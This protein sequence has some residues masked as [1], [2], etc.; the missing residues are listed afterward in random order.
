[1]WPDAEGPAEISDTEKSCRKKELSS[2]TAERE[3]STTCLRWPQSG[4]R[5]VA[6]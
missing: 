2:V 4:L 3:N 1:M 6:E 5:T